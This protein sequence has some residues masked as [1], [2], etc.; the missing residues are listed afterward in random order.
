MLSGPD[1]ELLAHLLP[2]DHHQGAVRRGALG[3]GQ[4]VNDV[5][6]GQIDRERGAFAPSLGGGFLLSGVGGGVVS[7][8]RRGESRLIAR[9]ARSGRLGGGE[10]RDLD[11]VKKASLAQ[12]LGA[13]A[14]RVRQ[15]AAIFSPLRN[16][17]SI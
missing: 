9:L 15:V 8:C 10:R 16:F 5:N 7:R 14:T 12:S 1:V 3:L 6:A 13:W 2:D 4:F 11:L 17:A